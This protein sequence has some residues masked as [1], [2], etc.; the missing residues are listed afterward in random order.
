MT[1]FFPK[2]PNDR[3]RVSA[4][5]QTEPRHACAR[6]CGGMNESHRPRSSGREDISAFCRD[7]RGD[8]AEGGRRRLACGSP[9]IYR[10]EMTDER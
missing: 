9:R 3:V 6:T 7:C 1:S 2:P 4:C 10:E 8:L 5:L